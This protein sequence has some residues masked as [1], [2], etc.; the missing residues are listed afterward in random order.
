MSSARAARALLALAL[1]SLSASARGDAPEPASAASEPAPA[2]PSSLELGGLLG[3]S[4]VFGDAANAEYEPSLRRV[5]VFGAVSLAYRSSY[6]IDPFVMIG[7]AALASGEST[8]PAGEWGDGGTLKQRLGTWIIAPGITLDLWRFRPLLG[9]GLGLVEQSNSFRGDESSSGQPSIA[10]QL[11]LG[12]NLLDTRR[13]RLD[14]DTRVVLV[15]GADIRF[16]T[17][18]LVARGDVLIY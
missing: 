15:P 12:F 18:A 13:F 3:P 4:V 17:L 2:T 1:A 5:G 14:V 9:L 7:Y 16:L 10:S 11:G 6:F 8:L